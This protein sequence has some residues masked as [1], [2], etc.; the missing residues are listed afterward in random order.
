VQYA[1]GKYVALLEAAHMQISSSRTANPYD[2]AHMESFFK[3]LKYE[4][5]HLSNYETYTDVSGRLPHFI[6]EV[7]NKKRLH[8]AFGI[9]T[10][11]AIRDDDSTNPNR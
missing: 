4:E 7:Y 9:L 11:T 5:V 2:N 8:S 6:D 10:P 1:C 3:T